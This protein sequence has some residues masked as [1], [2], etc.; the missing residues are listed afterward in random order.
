MKKTK[1]AF[2]M[3][4]LLSIAYVL[5]YFHRLCPAVVADDMMRDFATTGTLLGLMG[6]AYFYS[7][8]AMQLPAGL[9]TDS[10]GPRRTI[11]VF[12]IV[13]FAGSLVMGLSTSVGWA[14][15]GRTLVGFGVATL[16]VPTLKILA[17]WFEPAVFAR[18]TGILIAMGGVGSLIATA[19]LAMLTEKVGWRV[20]FIIVAGVTVALTVL[21]H[22]FV[23]DAPETE[24]GGVRPASSEKRGPAEAHG[25]RAG[26][27]LVLSDRSMWALCVW[28]FFTAAIFFSFGGLWGGPYLIHV[29]GLSKTGAGSVLSMTAL[30]M[31]IGSPL[32]SFLSDRVVG[33]RKPVL[34]VSG[35]LTIAVT[36]AF[37]F[38]SSRLTLPHLYALC[39]A[40]G[41]FAN[42]VV[43][44]GFAAVKELFPVKIAGTATGIANIFPFAGG[45]VFQPLMGRLIERHGVSAGVYTLRGY[46]DAFLSLFVASVIAFAACFFMR[47]TY[48]GKTGLDTS[49]VPD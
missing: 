17:T 20:A 38:L 18:L 2:L 8:A 45:A 42:S 6:A 29:H 32:L 34:V 24:T 11:T 12:F 16:F 44:V 22:L 15:F 13:A 40:M 33:G 41:M 30:G 5:V 26:F 35:A 36:A 1:R 7:Y 31:I 46:E 43:S 25:V 49:V 48:P 21:I 9:L 27:A 10:L 37:A 3:F 19:P 4:G 28:F 23:R 39:F 14:V 47:E